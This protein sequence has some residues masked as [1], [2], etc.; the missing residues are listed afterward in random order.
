MSR[1]YFLVG[2][3]DKMHGGHVFGFLSVLLGQFFGDLTVREMYES[4]V[5]EEDKS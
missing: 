2:F 1:R 5:E 3:N 4:E